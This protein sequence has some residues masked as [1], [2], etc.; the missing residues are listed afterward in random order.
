MEQRLELCIQKPRNA[1][2]CQKLEQVKKNSPS[3]T[4]E[5]IWPCQQLDFRLLAYRTERE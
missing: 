2:G 4:A 3:H 1:K 5:E